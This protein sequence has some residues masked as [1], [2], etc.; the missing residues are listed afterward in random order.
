MKN[1]VEVK[2]LVYL[3][4]TI[5]TL[6]KRLLERGRTSG[7]EDDNPACIKKRLVTYLQQT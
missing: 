3:E 2:G 7:R 6:E 4:C 5:E 1:D